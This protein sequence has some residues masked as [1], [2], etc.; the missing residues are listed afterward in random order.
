MNESCHILMSHVTYEWVIS[1]IHESCHISVIHKR[2]M[3]H[4]NESS[5]T[6][7]VQ[8]TYERCPAT[9]I[10]LFWEGKKTGTHTLPIYW[11]P[12]SVIMYVCTHTSDYVCMYAYIHVCMYVRIHTC[13]TFLS[14]IHLFPRSQ[15]TGTIPIYWGP[16]SVMR[17]FDPSAIIYISDL[18]E[19]QV[20]KEKER[21]GGRD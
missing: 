15:K 19:A 14:R 8:I 13:I 9:C 21:E 6:W 20:E 12:E 17:T 7:M 5:H 10:W 3:S 2:V 4:M 18:S 1:H 16:E 11:G